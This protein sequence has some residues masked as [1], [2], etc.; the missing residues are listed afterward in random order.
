MAF[1]CL[2]VAMACLLDFVM[3]QTIV[4][5]RFLGLESIVV[6]INEVPLFIFCF[7]LTYANDYLHLS[8]N[9]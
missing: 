4:Q 1:E 8:M 5:K 3:T 2:K 9:M 7:V 6:N